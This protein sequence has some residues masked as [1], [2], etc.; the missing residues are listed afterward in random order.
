MSTSEGKTTLWFGVCNQLQ[1]QCLLYLE[2]GV[3]TFSLM[4]YASLPST[5]KWLQDP[6][7]ITV[8]RNKTQMVVKDEVLT[9]TAVHKS[10]Y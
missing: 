9:H 1:S 5:P 7:I 2:S 8:C 10:V 6:R 4:F 3:L